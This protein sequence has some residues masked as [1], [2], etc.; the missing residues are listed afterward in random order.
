MKSKVLIGC[1]SVDRACLDVTQQICGILSQAG[2]VACLYGDDADLSEVVDASLVESISECS[3]VVTVGGDGTIIKWGKLAAM[4]SIPL[5]GVNMGRVGFM[6]TL[7]PSDI[8]RIPEI[9]ASP[10]EISRRMLM[11]C[12]IISGG[13]ERLSKLVMNDVVIS[14]D[15]DSKLPEFSVFCKRG[16]APETEVSTIRADGV[17]L[18][19]PTGSTAYSL[20]AGGP[21]LAPDLEGIEMTALCPHTLFNRPMIFSAEQLVAVRCRNYQSSR[22]SVSI[23]GEGGIPFGEGDELWL[24]KS[25]FTLSLIESGVGFYGAVHDKLMAPLK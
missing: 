6:A 8:S 1:N 18:S 7:E 21:I 10:R 13:K 22:V 25:G 2:M 5:L 12:S 24:K 20:S 23:D 17:I 19:T 15:S 9:L 11:E 4:N 3:S 14:R 16:D